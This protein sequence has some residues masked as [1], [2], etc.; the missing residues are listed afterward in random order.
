MLTC[1][2][3]EFG[4]WEWL[5]TPFLRNVV[6]CLLPPLGI[7]LIGFDASPYGP[8]PMYLGMMLLILGGGVLFC[9]EKCI[10]W[11]YSLVVSVFVLGAWVILRVG[12][13]WFFPLFDPSYYNHEAW[14]DV[15]RAS[16]IVVLFLGLWIA[17]Y[18]KLF[19]FGMAGLL[20]GASSYPWVVG[21]WEMIFE[22]LNAG[23]RLSLEGGPNFLG[24]YSSS[25]VGVGLSIIVYSLLRFASGRTSKL[26]VFCFLIVGVYV[27]ALH[28]L[29]LIASESRQSWVAVV[30]SLVFLI[31][32]FFLVI[33][34]W[35]KGENARYKVHF[36]W[37]V[38][39]F[40]V[41]I[42]L[43]F[44][45]RG[46]IIERFEDSCRTINALATFQFENIDKEGDLGKRVLMW[47]DGFSAIA[48]KPLV[49]YGPGFTSHIRKSTE[50][51]S[52]KNLGG[53]FHNTYI[54][55]AVGLGLPWLIAWVGV[56]VMVVFFAVKRAF[57]SLHSF[58]VVLV[59]C[60]FVITFLVSGLAEYRLHNAQEFGMYLFGFSLLFG[61]ALQKCVPKSQPTKFFTS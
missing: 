20:L 12:A 15:F 59:G 18:P 56:H 55:L 57:E 61:E 31:S 60:S 44:P 36:S 39:V 38:G 14:W 8:T 49:G 48:E 42:L 26:F 50:R 10:F 51:E 35:K 33:N 9:Q 53:Q 41:V 13:S 47:A 43:A 25:M 19:W 34:G 3:S 45:F 58:F 32:L 23:G 1:R 54:H 29:L 27:F 11:R 7:F 2:G 40:F 28:F 52:I 24:R 16:G 17:H 37:G 6:F 46:V 22:S 4:Y 5:N 30:F 21:G